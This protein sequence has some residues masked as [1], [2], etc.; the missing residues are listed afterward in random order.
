MA[1]PT[2]GVP[3]AL[4]LTLEGRR[5]KRKERGRMSDGPPKPERSTLSAA[6]EAGRAI[7]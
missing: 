1:K 7:P 6:K 5:S 2:S 4:P 3:K